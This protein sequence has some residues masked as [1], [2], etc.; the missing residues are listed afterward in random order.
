MVYQEHVIISNTKP[1]QQGAHTHFIKRVT[2]TTAMS[3]GCEKKN[4][5]ITTM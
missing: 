3:K 4:E 1:I 2:I 5:E